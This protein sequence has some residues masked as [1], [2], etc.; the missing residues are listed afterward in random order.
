MAKKK[1]AASRMIPVK[2]GGP[3][4]CLSIPLTT[5]AFQR[6]LMLDKKLVGTADYMGIA[7][8]SHDEYK[9]E[10]RWAIPRRKKAAHDAIL[11]AGLPLDGKS[12]EHRG[13]IIQ[14]LIVAR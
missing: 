11:K 14:H 5:R 6:L 9:Q 8:W 7:P 13:L 1:K 4:A 3:V 2:S 10:M 12:P